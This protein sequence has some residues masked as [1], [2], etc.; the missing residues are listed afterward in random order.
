MAVELHILAARMEWES[1]LE[2]SE[3]GSEFLVVFYFS[4]QVTITQL[5]SF[6]ENPLLYTLIIFMVFRMCNKC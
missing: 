6:F 4:T 5:Y 2:E 1:N 3:Y